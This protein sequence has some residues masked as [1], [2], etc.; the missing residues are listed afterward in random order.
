MPVDKV[1]L[2]GSYAWG[3]PT[4]ASDIDIAVVSSK[5]KKFDSIERIEFLSD[6]ARHLSP[7]LDID[8]DVIGFTSEEMKK[9]SYF[10][11]AAEVLQKGKIIYKIAA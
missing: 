7:E 8:I 3:K 2:F 9:A 1:Y 5:F 6:I 10:D 11:I 4:S